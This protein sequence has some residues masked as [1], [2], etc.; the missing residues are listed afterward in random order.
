MDDIDL[1]RGLGRDAR[2]PSPDELAPARE[3]LASVM[4]AERPVARRPAVRTE[5]RVW[6]WP[7][8]T[9]LTV[10]LATAIVAA[11]ALPVY[12]NSG[13]PVGDPARPQV[14]TG[15]ATADP[16]PSRPAAQ[17]AG[18]VLTEAAAAA[19][20]LPDTQPRP[21]QFFYVQIVEKSAT[22]RQ[23]WWFSVDGTRDGLAIGMDQQ[24]RN[25]GET[26]LG[27]CPP[28][29]PEGCSP[30]PA[31]LSHLPTDEPGMAG[32]VQRG[33]LHRT[34]AVPADGERR[35][36]V[37]FG[38]YLRPQAR[39]ALLRALADKPDLDLVP[40]ASDGAGRPSI[41]VKWREP[42]GSTGNSPMQDCGLLFDP[43][44]YALNGIWQDGTV[45]AI[46]RGGFVDRPP[47][48]P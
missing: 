17:S 45:N 18:Q 42:R 8:L 21:D 32:W 31:Y 44:T 39:A 5:R 9:G 4:A 47:Q 14:A 43:H 19:L 41:G 28:T 2:L 1:I 38:Q 46:I 26:K 6:G 27:G 3:R 35:C 16:G 29:E 25:T 10:V 22:P 40:A 30:R 34:E 33:S 13:P 15:A 7:Q 11:V 48:R 23:E 12:L 37:R 20:R 36:L 24:G